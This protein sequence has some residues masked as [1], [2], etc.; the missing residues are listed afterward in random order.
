M[1]QQMRQIINDVFYDLES[2]L[3]EC[4]ETVDAETLADTVGDRMHDLCEEYRAMPYALRRS[5]VL[6]ICNEYA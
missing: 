6:R 1:E 3:A 5:M 4:G 2:A